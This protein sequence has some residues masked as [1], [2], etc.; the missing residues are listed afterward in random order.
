MKNETISTPKF[1]YSKYKSYVFDCDGVLLNSN[2]IKTQAFYSVALPYGINAAKSLVNYHIMNGGVS[3]Y[4]KFQFFIT[5]ILGKTVI[6]NELKQLLLNFSKE[7]KKG[8]MSC[9]VAIG[10]KSLREKTLKSKW[11]VVS[12]GDQNE[13][14]EVFVKRDLTKFFDGGIFGSPETKEQIL[15]REIQNDNIQYPAIYL[16]DSKYDYSVAKSFGIDFL[17]ISGWSEVKEWSSFC[18]KNNI[19]SLAK[20]SNLL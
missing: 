16:G 8:L 5:D 9:E 12:G 18:E 19:K 1:H 4:K 17:F 15:R 2:K 14:R 3:R 11:L 10:L 13:L 6:E 20:I 7:V